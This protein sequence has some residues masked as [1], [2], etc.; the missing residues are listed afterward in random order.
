LARKKISNLKLRTLKLDA[1]GWDAIT[2]EFERICP[3]QKNPLHFG[4]L[5]SWEFGGKD[6]LRGISIYD[7]GEY[8]HFISYGLTELY[9]KKVKIRSVVAMEWNLHLR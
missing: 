5:I 2:K 8:W 9:E 7:G 1:S 4:T 3:T 6:P